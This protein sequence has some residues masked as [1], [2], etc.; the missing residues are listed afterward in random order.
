MTILMK[1]HH[2]WR[3]NYRMRRDLDHL[4]V[5]ELSERLNDCINNDRTRTPEGKIGLLSGRTPIGEMWK[6]L[7]TEIFEECVIRNYPYGTLDI[8]PYRSV[9]DHAFDPIPDMDRAFNDLRIGDKPYLLKFGKAEHLRKSLELGEFRFGSA[10]DFDS[11]KHNHARRDRELERP[12]KLNPRNP[13]ISGRSSVSY[14]TDYFLFCLAARYSSRL[15]GDFSSSACLIIYDPKPFLQRLRN[16]MHSHLPGWQVEVIDVV[17][18]D[19]IR[20][21]PA[22]IIVPRFKPF[23]HAY[24]SEVRIT[25]IPTSPLQ[26][27]APFN[28]KIGPLADCATLVEL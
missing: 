14:P 17:Y 25:G 26:N 24:Q 1:R 12:V 22:D 10:S 8:S 19:P 13:N 2:V 4:S 20:I 3:L 9:M 21:K 27:L 28:I 7:A 18:Y 5:A 11:A 16:A 15:F 6:I 23:R